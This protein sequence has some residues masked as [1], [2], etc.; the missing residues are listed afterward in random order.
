MDDEYWAAPA[1]TPFQ[2]QIGP[3]HQVHDLQPPI[4]DA[5]FGWS[6]GWDNGGRSATIEM[7]GLPVIDQPKWRRPQPSV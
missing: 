7:Q 4:T 1:R 2:G 5:L 6:I 3:E